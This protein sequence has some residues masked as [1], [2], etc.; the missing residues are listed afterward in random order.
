MNRKRTGIITLAIGSVAMVLLAINPSLILTLLFGWIG[1]LYRV[2]PDV[3]VRWDGVAIFLVGLGMLTLVLHRI[4]SWLRREMTGQPAIWRWRSTVLVVGLVICLFAAGISMVGVTHQTAWLFTDREPARVPALPKNPS[5]SRL[6]LKMMGL[7]AHNFHDV[8]GGFPNP[9]P[10]EP[11]QAEQSWATRILPY[12]GYQIKLDRQKPWDHPDNQ[13]EIRKL[14]PELL[15]PDVVP[16]VL[17]DGN[18]YGVSHYAG[19]RHVF[20]AAES[21]SVLDI[22]D[23]PS[24]TLMIGEVSAN[25]PPWAKPRTNREPALGINRSPKGFGGPAGHRGAQFLMVDGSVRFFSHDIDPAVLKA[26]GTPNGNETIEK[27]LLE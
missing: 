12:S 19:N 9:M 26:L 3:T 7:A 4:I 15:N 16:I 10:E 13:R 2:L 11:D 22:K 27:P 17:R 1:Y 23:G 8:S 24:N 21:L 20:E 6:N 18:G 5:G 14:V 25:F